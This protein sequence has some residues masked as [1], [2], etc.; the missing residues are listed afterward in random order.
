M[1][2][3]LDQKIELCFRTFNNSNGAAME[4]A[5]SGLTQENERKWPIRNEHRWLSLRAE[6]AQGGYR[7]DQDV[8]DH[9][10]IAM[11]NILEVKSVHV[12]HLE[13]VV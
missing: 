10:L 9:R 1:E 4:H 5:Q 2:G 7:N 11:I 6:Y 3:K 8:I 13:E 12:V